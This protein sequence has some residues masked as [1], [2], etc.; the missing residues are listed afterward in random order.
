MLVVTS[1]IAERTLLYQLVEEYYP[2]FKA[3]LAE[4]GSAL[5]GYV[6]QEFEGY[7]APIVTVFDTSDT[8]IGTYTLTQGPNTLGFVGFT[9]TVGIGRAHLLADQGE[10]Q[11]TGIDNVRVGLATV[12]VPAAVWL[13]GSGLLGLVGVARRKASRDA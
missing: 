10:T 13:F 7:L 4:Q 9:S 3:H 8:L 6:E 5:P 1:A 12:P 2:A 11:D